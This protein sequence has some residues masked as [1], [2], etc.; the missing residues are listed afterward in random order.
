[1]RLYTVLRGLMASNDYNQEQL[2]RKLSLSRASVGHRMV[3]ITPFTLDE[4]YTILDLFHTPHTR[5][6][7]VFPKDGIPNPTQGGISP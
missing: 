7:E 5:L 3:G 1:M 4:A 6:H 2:G